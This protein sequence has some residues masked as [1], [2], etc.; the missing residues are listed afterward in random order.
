MAG[1]AALL[2]AAGLAWV[3][4]PAL[5]PPRVVGSVPIT[6]DLFPKQ[7]FVTDG[8]RLYLG[9]V[10]AGN[11]AL[12]QVSAEAGETSQIATPFPNVQVFDIAPNHSSLLAGSFVT[13]GET[14]LPLWLLPLPSG[15][16]HRLGDVHA[17]SA[18]WS[19]DGQQIVYATESSLY[20]VKE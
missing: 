15:S 18:G 19:P 4:R 14:E 6:N 11:G 3:F 9:E 8:T 10:V 5:P 12:G 13:G 7:N 16:P 20:L 1:A 2:L 17:H